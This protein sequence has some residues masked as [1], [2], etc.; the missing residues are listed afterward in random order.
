MVNDDGTYDAFC[1]GIRRFTSKTEQ[2]YFVRKHVESLLN[3][4]L[5]SDNAIRVLLFL[6]AT[7][8]VTC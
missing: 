6:L 1:M 4:R 3:E 5:C 2:A 7:M 8:E